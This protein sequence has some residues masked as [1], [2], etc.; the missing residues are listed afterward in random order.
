M[1]APIVRAADGSR[2]E[3]RSNPER[4]E[5]LTSLELFAGA[6]GLALGIHAAGFQHV[7]LVEW[8]KFTAD[9][10][11]DNSERVLD[12]DPALVLNVDARS[13]DYEQFAGKIELLSG[14]PP[15]QPFSTGGRNKSYA[16]L[17]NMFPVFLDAVASVRPKAILIENVRGL[18]RR[19]FSDYYDYIL[20][21]LQFPLQRAAENEDWQAHYER[22]LKTAETEFADE[23]QYLVTYQL[24]DTADYGV[25]QRRERVF[26]CAFRKDL[27]IEPF[28]M[29]PTHSKDAL[30]IDQWI[31][32][33]Y[34]E[35]HGISSYDYLGPRDKKVLETIRNRFLES[36]E[37]SPW[38]TVRDAVGDLPEPVLR[39]RKEKI[40]N[41]I[42]HP[43]ARIYEGHTG[44]FF[45][46]PAKALK[47]GTHGT[48]GGE[49]ILRVSNDG[50]VVRY[51][52]TREAAASTTCGTPSPRSCWSK[53]R[54][55][56]WCRR[57]SATLRLRT[58]WTPTPTSR[59]TCS[60]AFAR[61]GE[62][63]K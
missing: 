11:R 48:P 49:N 40:P 6:G 10:L 17:R 19:N 45:D 24:L 2:K 1:A 56:R 14:G 32:G 20:K 58:P 35:R 7:A 60:A 4:I 18:L 3:L 50:E 33:D 13:I 43:G 25:P 42:Q 15:C 31:T 51:F 36:E 62:R 46:Y 38:R 27:G 5:V 23:E 12:M 59:P 55:R 57:S 47:A 8:D 29:K 53:A 39:G 44:S 28:R 9:T 16:D 52:T 37:R 41:H 54:T 34:W 30:L 63:L 21:R 22:L 61:L 26:I